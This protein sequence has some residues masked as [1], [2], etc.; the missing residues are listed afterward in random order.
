MK[1]FTI[2]VNYSLHSLVPRQRARVAEGALCDHG[3]PPWIRV[4]PRLQGDRPEVRPGQSG[5]RS[6]VNN[7]LL[8]NNSEF[9]HKIQNFRQIS[10]L[11]S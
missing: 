4:R 2:I 8:S 5:V 6:E 9:L 7:S 11:F 10:D 1:K 3:D